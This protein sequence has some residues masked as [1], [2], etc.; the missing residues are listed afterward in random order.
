MLG[1]VVMAGKHTL[2]NDPFSCYSFN[3]SLI[4]GFLAKHNMLDFQ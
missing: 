3:I 1:P 2:L 4:F